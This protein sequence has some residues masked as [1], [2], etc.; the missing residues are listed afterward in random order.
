MRSRCRGNWRTGK[1]SG[2]GQNK[3]AQNAP[4]AHESGGLGPIGTSLDRRRGSHGRCR[5]AGAGLFPEE[6]ATFKKVVADYEKARGDKTDYSIM[7]FMAL[8]Q[9]TASALTSGDVPDLIFHNV[10]D[11]ILP[12]NA[13][14]DMM[15][16]AIVYAVPPIIMN[17]AFRGYMAASLTTAGVKG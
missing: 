7:P 10:F 17:Y 8:N 12:R 3:P 2:D 13:W 14:N 15:A 16:A 5:L 4:P 9:T 6:D 1:D 11:M